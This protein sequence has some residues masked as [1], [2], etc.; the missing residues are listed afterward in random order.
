MLLVSAYLLAWVPLN[1]AA[2]LMSTIPSLKMRGAKA[3]VELTLHGVVAAFSVAASRMLAGRSPA[4]PAAAS[5]AVIASGLVAIQ[6]LYWTVLPRDIAPGSQL[7]KAAFWI[8]VTLVLLVLVR[9]RTSGRADER[10]SG[11][12]D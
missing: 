2:E 7:P 9:K 12:A 10:T 5:I 6:S 1:F 11:Q 4:A 8:A 3:I